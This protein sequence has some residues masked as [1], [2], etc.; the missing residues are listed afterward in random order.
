MIQWIPV[1][2]YAGLIFYISSQPYLGLPNQI[3]LLDPESLSLHLFEFIPLGFLTARA[4]SR[5]HALNSFNSF[6]FPSFIG[7]LYGLSDEVH[8]YFVPGRTSSIIDFMADTAGVMIGVF[9]WGFLTRGKIKKEHGDFP[10]SVETRG[11]TQ[12]L[13]SESNNPT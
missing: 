11:S 1:L 10:D 8:Q 9:L 2:L 4:A 7:S 12:T 5:T 3:V 6:N 13:K